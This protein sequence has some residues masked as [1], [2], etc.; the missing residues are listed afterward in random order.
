MAHLG[1]EVLDEKGNRVGTVTSCAIDTEGFLTGQAF[2]DLKYS[3]E[4]QALFI[5]QQVKKQTD[6]RNKD[7]KPGERL[8]SPDAAVVVSRFPK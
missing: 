6:L 4:H 5:Y 2:V 8:S 1:D 7:L 3:K